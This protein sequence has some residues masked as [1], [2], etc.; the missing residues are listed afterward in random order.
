VFSAAG[1]GGLLAAVLPI[2]PPGKVGTFHVMTYLQPYLVN[3]IPN[4]LF[5]GA[6][7]FTL[8]VVFRKSMPVFTAGVLLVVLHVVARNLAG[9]PGL[10][11]VL[12]WLDPLGFV[13]YSTVTDLWTSVERNSVQIPLAGAY[14]ANRLLWLGV[15]VCF[16]AVGFARFR[17]SQT[18]ESSAGNAGK[19]PAAPVEAGCLRSQP[20]CLPPQ[21]QRH[22]STGGA[23][24]LCLQSALFDFWS[25]LRSIYFHLILGAIGLSLI[26]LTVVHTTRWGTSS[27]PVTYSVLEF[28]NNSF[29]LFVLVITAI[30]AGELIWRERE[31]RSHEVYDALP[32]ADWVSLVSKLLALMGALVVVAGFVALC[33]V[34]TQAY[35]G[36]YRFEPGLYLKEL[37]VIKLTEY[38]LFCVLAVVV[39]ILINQKYLAHFALALFYVVHVNLSGLGIHHNL[40]RFASNPGYVYSDMNGYGHLVTGLVWFRLYWAAFVLLLGLAAYLVWPRGCE[41]SVR[42][43]LRL[44]TS[45]L[46][47]KVR[48]LGLA[49]LGGFLCVGGWIFY[50]T[51]ILNPYITGW[52][53]AEWAAR[54]E[55]TYGTFRNR[56]QPKV[57]AT[58]LQVDLY[59]S[60]RGLHTAGTMRLRNKSGQPI[61][62]L[63]VTLPKPEMTVK[64][65]APQCP[66]RL[67]RQDPG[68]GVYEFRLGSPLSPNEDVELSFDLESRP[69][70]F[71]NGIGDTT[72]VDNGSFVFSLHVLPHIGYMGFRELEGRGERITHGLPADRQRPKGGVSVLNDSD[73]ID[74]EAVLSTERDQTA[75]APGELKREWESGDRRYFHYKTAHPILNICA[76][77]SAR[78]AVQKTRWQNVSIE[79]YHHPLHAYNVGRMIQAVQ[80]SLDYYTRA[81]GPYPHPSVRIGEFPRFARFAQYFP[82]LIPFSESAG[83][84]AWMKP[85][86]DEV[87]IP[88]AVTAHEM[89]HEWWGHQVRGANVPGEQM[90]TETLANYSASMVVK[91]HFSEKTIQTML[92]HELGGYL[93]G[94]ANEPDQ[95]VPL[96]QASDHYYV[97]YQKGRLA[98]FAL[99]DYIGEEAVNRALADYLTAFRYREPPYPVAQDLIER[100]RRVT[101]PEYAYLIRDLFETVTL[102]E[103]KA[104]RAESRT[105][106]G[107]LYKVTLEVESR[108]MSTAADGL[109]ARAPL[110]DWIEIGLESD[111]GRWGCVERRKITSERAVL[112]LV[113]NLR[114]RRAA[115]DPW[116][117]LIDRHPEDNV[118]EVKEVR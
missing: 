21:P 75:L 56:P 96:V 5:L 35:Q 84:I 89:A 73:W 90:L 67:E 27:Y 15:G 48:T 85:G 2:Y 47:P 71:R 38:W 16:L 32:V 109:E 63:Q 3:V 91:K 43:R 92:R 82:G 23:L 12:S 80:A 118:I 68:Q 52:E 22:F 30:Y 112:T 60:V 81:F 31:N 53:S 59:P 99:Q 7:F 20:S 50:N 1:L 74:F 34:A 108:K 101:P 94:R 87:D 106:P 114:P 98:M 11:K 113:S 46:T 4:A 39:H 111:G 41:T 29:P 103:N 44:V 116:G 83:F 25:I 8:A 19:M 88:F 54:Y 61:P 13:G 26:A 9:E 72:V 69:R 40:L 64:R 14:L 117:K 33:G 36:Y 115:I 18:V 79:V 37:F 76:F 42:Q 107:G 110:G 51:N 70:G 10:E 102:Y 66:H 78:Y 49:A 62:V 104:V 95:E 105:Q 45:R 58:R 93:W 86:A 100:L 17:F 97:A 55:K 57:V 28:L 65:L 6:V 77:L 24:G